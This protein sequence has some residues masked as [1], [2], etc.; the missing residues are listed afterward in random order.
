MFFYLIF[1]FF[2][3]DLFSYLKTGL[4]GVMLI[5]SQSDLNYALVKGDNWKESTCKFFDNIESFFWGK[6]EI[7]C[8]KHI[9]CKVSLLFCILLIKISYETDKYK[10]M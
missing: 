5:L 1:H 10:Y 3:S 4:L 7:S 9:F 2:L 8:K 6:K